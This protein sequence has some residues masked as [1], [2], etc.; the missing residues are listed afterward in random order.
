MTSSAVADASPH[1][2]S[3]AGTSEPTSRKNR[4]RPTKIAS[5]TSLPIVSRFTTNALCLMPRT[6]I[7]QMVAITA[8]MSAARPGPVLSDGQ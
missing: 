7:Q 5:G 3:P 8:V 2:T 1:V 4:P 6:L